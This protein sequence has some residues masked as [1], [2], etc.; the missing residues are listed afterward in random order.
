[1][2]EYFK[3]QKGYFYKFKKNGEK[4][5]ISEEEY[6][7]KNKKMIGSGNYEEDVREQFLSKK[8]NFVGKRCLDIGSR[9]GLNCITLV[10]LGATEVIGIDIDDSRFHQMPSNSRIKL[11]KK[12]LL[13][14]DEN[15][16]FDV[17]TC[18]LWNMNLPQYNEIIFKI[19]LLLNE[20][21]VV[22]IGI[23]DYMYKHNKYG[24]SV[25]D[26]LKRNFSNVR[27]L[28]DNN[29]FQWILLAENPK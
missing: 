10:N 6:N 1:M 8:I 16:K 26:L 18:F 21:G 29:P 7:K 28:D 20:K 5:R 9:D 14:M 4:K 13:E 23:H 22:Y 2:V 27:I 15:E 19:K 11:I 24:G 3:T 12:N 25:P 17:I